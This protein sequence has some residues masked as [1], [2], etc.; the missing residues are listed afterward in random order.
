MAKIEFTGYVHEEKGELLVRMEDSGVDLDSFTP[1]A[2]EKLRGAFYE[3]TL[4]VEIDTETGD[5]RL[6][7][8]KI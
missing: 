7:E 1:E 2:L 5:M 3:V 8:T 4:K 6:I